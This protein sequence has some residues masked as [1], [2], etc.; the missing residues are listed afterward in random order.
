VSQRFQMLQEIQLSKE[1]MDQALIDKLVLIID[2]IDYTLCQSLL[3]WN[4]ISFIFRL[5]L[6][7]YLIDKVCLSLSEDSKY[8]IK[9]LPNGDLRLWILP[10]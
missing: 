3:D 6:I 1:H 10:L 7:L 2:H 4:D 8:C 5:T 9:F